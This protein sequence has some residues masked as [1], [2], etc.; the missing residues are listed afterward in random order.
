MYDGLDWWGSPLSSHMQRTTE[1]DFTVGMQV[2]ARSPCW[3]DSPGGAAWSTLPIEVLQCVL[4][5]LS[6]RATCVLAWICSGWRRQVLKAPRPR[7]LID[8]QLRMHQ[9]AAKARREQEF[10]EAE[11]EVEMAKQLSRITDELYVS[12][13][14]WTD[15]QLVAEGITAVVTV[16]DGSKMVTALPHLV[17]VSFMQ[18]SALF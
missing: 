10:R 1:H 16:L 2:H 15:E 11:A 12:G 9:A 13:D 3:L 7:T 5:H 6:G 4:D 17:L 8:Y 14:A 18:L